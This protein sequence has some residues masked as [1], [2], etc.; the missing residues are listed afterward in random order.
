M[1]VHIP[2][3]TTA[4]KAPPVDLDVA[5][6]RF[7]MVEPIMWGFINNFGPYDQRPAIIQEAF[8]YMADAVLRSVEA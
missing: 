4:P 5:M 3:N 2:T 1:N 6:A 7:R 8:V